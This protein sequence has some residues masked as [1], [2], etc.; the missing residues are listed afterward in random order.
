M[1]EALI[2]CNRNDSFL[3][4][5]IGKITIN[6]LKDVSNYLLEE[7]LKKILNLVSKHENTKQIILFIKQLLIGAN[8]NL[9]QKLLKTMQEVLI[10]PSITNKSTTSEE[11]TALNLINL[12]IAEKLQM[13]SSHSPLIQSFANDHHNDSNYNTNASIRISSKI[14]LN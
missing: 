10:N 4:K 12:L 6:Q 2:L 11:I 1:T 14:N 5:L 9:S 7:T 13:S 3:L 8:L